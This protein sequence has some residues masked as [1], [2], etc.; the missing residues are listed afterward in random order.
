MGAHALIA[1]ARARGVLLSASIPLQRHHRRARTR[2]GSPPKRS[3][4]RAAETWC[5][6]VVLVRLPSF[7]L[8]VVGV[9][10]ERWDLAGEQ[11]PVLGIP[12]DRCE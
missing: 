7:V 12:I 9:V 10:V 8:F 5:A 6:L 1:R 2:L 4:P 3:R 11:A